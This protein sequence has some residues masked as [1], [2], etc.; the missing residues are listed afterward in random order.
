MDVNLQDPITKR[1]ALHI[2]AFTGYVPLARKL[3]E[4]GADADKTGRLGISPVEI[5]LRHRNMEVYDLLME[6]S[7]RKGSDSVDSR[8]QTMF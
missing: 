8:V 7:S 1:T 2:T 6:H 4:Y 5:A 3:L